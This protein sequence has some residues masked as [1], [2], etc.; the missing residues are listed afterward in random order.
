MCDAAIAAP[1]LLHIIITEAA[2]PCCAHHVCG[3]GRNHA[4]RCGGVVFQRGWQ[5]M[6]DSH[7]GNHSPHTGRH[8]LGVA[9]TY[10]ATRKPGDVVP[11]YV[12]T[13]HFRLPPAHDV[14]VVMVGPGTGLAPF[15]GFCQEREALLKQGTKGLWVVARH[16]HL[17]HSTTSPHHTTPGQQLAPAYLY[18]GCRRQKQ[19]FLYE[20]E[21]RAWVASGVLT[22]LYLAFSRD[23]ATKDYVQHH[24]LQHSAE[25]WNTL[26]QKGC[27]YVC[28]DAKHMARDVHHALHDVA[29]QAG[30]YSSSQAEAFVKALADGNR[31]QKDVW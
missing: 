19:D 16:S 28:G 15:R 10:L 12:R 18:F 29:Q 23:G 7:D 14:P 5:G 8:H 1:L 6:V 22:A 3:G 20:A 27:L 13:S 17:M 11:V 24:M 30:G 26:Q 4:H 9:S 31:Y 2:Y 25:L 21:L